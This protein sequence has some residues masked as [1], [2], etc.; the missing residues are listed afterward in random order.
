M[1]PCIRCGETKPLK[2]FYAHPQMG[3]GHLNKCKVCCREYARKRHYKKSRDPE[4]REAERL[5]SIE[6]FRRNRHRWNVGTPTHEAARSAAIRAHPNTPTGMERHHWSYNREHWADVI[7][8]TISVHRCLHRHMSYDA[9]L[10]YFRTPRGHLLDTKRKHVR[11]MLAV[12]NERSRYQS[13][14]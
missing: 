3:D 1:K 14:A 11:W 6:K 12:L 4:W 2:S 7:F 10:K 8:V 5:R 13:A 9:D